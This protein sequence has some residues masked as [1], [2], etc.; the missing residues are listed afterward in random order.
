MKMKNF[1]YKTS[2][3]AFAVMVTAWVT[4]FL[5]DVFLPKWFFCFFFLLFVL[6]LL[7]CAGYKRPHYWFYIRHRQDNKKD[8]GVL[9]TYS[10][11]TPFYVFGDSDGVISQN[12]FEI[13]C[14][15]YERLFVSINSEKEESDDTDAK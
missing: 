1:D 12:C 4:F 11:Y 15:D 8:V 10:P 7:W 2:F 6:M 13:S 3:E 5:I 9:K 14:D